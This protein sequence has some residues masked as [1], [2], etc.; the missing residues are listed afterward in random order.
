M[1]TRDLTK[2]DP[3]G[4][5]VIDNN[6]NMK[7]LEAPFSA[8]CVDDVGNLKA[9][10]LVYVNEVGYTA[11]HELIYLINSQPYDHYYFVLDTSY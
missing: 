8:Y 10:T 3:Q 11:N 7:W 4:I 1:Q 9:N 2:P 6:G 5:Y